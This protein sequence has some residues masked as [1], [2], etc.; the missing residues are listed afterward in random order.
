MCRGVRCGGKHSRG[1]Y[2]L[3][4]GDVLPVVGESL[5]E[6]EFGADGG[7]IRCSVVVIVWFRVSEVS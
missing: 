2:E 1:G 4:F 5:G 7:V 6:N 3:G